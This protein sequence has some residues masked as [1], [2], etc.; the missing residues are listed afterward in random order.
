[1]LRLGLIGTGAFAS[2]CLTPALRA[3]AGVRFHSVLSRDPERGHAFAA[4]E[5]AGAAH[6]ELERFLAD[7]ELDAVLVAT[8]DPTHE[9]IVLAA[10]A[11]RKHVLCE[12]PLATT[13]AA[14]RRM[15]D[16]CARAGVRLALGYH[17]RHHPAHR[18]LLGWVGAG[19]LGR[20]VRVRVRFMAH[21]TDATN[22]RC[23]PPNPWWAMAAV[24][25]HLVD[26]ACALL[27]EAV[28]DVHARFSSPV[29]GAP[30][31][32][33]AVLS[34]GFAGGA[35]ADVEASMTLPASPSRLEVSGTKGWVASDG[36]VGPGGGT[37]VRDGAPVAF[38][39]GDPYTGEIEDF[40]RAIAE[41]RDA[42]ASGAVGVRNVEVLE[43]AALSSA[44]GVRVRPE[45]G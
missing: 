1:M 35:S 6:A 2:R 16:A 13:A 42:A 12:K 15:R 39:A 44:R 45:R 5:G 14:A 18:L 38:P 43:A 10:A 7:P 33:L 27:G 32:E 4:R 17:T 24:G 29:L 3:A 31:E 26:L 41:G 22:W 23:R 20:L 36:T 9:A 40:A 21:R 25:T 30:N 37:M 11:A 28:E 8:P 19:E 34:L